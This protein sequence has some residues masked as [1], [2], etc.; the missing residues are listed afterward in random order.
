MT[1]AEIV[2]ALHGHGAVVGLDWSGPTPD[3]WP[4]IVIRGNIPHPLLQAITTANPGELAAAI[5]DFDERSAIHSDG[6][7]SP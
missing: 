7:S 3:A 5:F 1:P 4:R 6:A 2:T